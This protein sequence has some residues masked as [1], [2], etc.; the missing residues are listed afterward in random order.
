M[1]KPVINLL[2]LLAITLLLVVGCKERQITKVMNVPEH[3][4][5]IDEATPIDVQKAIE[6]IEPIVPIE[7]EEMAKIIEED[8]ESDV[9]K[10][11][12]EA[13]SIKP[14]DEV[15][16]EKTETIIVAK[17]ENLEEVDERA[18]MLKELDALLEDVLT[19]LDA[20]EEDDLSDDNLFDE[21]G[22]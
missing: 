1:K 18:L 19:K 7:P 4:L 15:I 6:P 3:D 22:D 13:P 10:D 20:V 12:I 5:A 14:S 17:S 21:G 8:S 2:L 11:E 9:N 16:D